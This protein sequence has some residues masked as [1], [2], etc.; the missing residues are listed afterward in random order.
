MSHIKR[1][2]VFEHLR[3]C[4][5]C[6]NSDPAVYRYGFRKSIV[7]LNI[8]TPEFTDTIDVLKFEQVNFTTCFK[9]YRLPVIFLIYFVHFYAPPYDSGEVLWFHVG[10]PCVCP[11]ICFLFPDDNLSKHRWIFTKFG[12]CIDIVLIWFGI[13]NG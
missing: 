9:G 3:T 4:A 10:R 12:M 13:A 6:T 2:S 8:G 1:K 5:K 7:T 11:S